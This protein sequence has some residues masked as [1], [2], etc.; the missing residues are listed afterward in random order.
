MQTQASK[1]SKILNQH[2]WRKQN[3]PGQNQ[4]QIVSI[5]QYSCAEDLEEKLQHMEGTY[6]KKKKK[7]KK[8]A[9]N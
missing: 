5:D 4:N 7:K 3:I 6:P 9:K 1:A 8:N 2:R